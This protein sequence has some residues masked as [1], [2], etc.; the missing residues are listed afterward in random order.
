M[1]PGIV[2][3]NHYLTYLSFIAGILLVIS[4][5]GL[6]KKGKG[7]LRTVE[8]IF[9]RVNLLTQKLT[10]LN[11]KR[12]L[13]VEELRH[14]FALCLKTTAVLSLYK[15][16]R[17]KDNRRFEKQMRTYRAHTYQLARFNPYL[18]RLLKF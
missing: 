5:I 1:L 16:L 11:R 14:A 7:L 10:E 6:I 4:I 3:Y 12:S 18:K 9:N 17:N 2:T 8:D 13:I 15:Y